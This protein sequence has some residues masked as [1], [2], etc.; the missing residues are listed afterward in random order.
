MGM[1]LCEVWSLNSNATQL[2]LSYLR[3]ELSEVRDKK[4]LLPQGK[5][6][7]L[8]GKTD[9]KR[10]PTHCLFAFQ[11]FFFKKPTFLNHLS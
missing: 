10:I 4:S 9:E 2:C 1:K 5:K 7:H 3:F 11:L 6:N 8:K